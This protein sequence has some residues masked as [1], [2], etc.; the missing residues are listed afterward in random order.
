M[1]NLVDHAERELRAAGYFDEDGMYDGMIGPAVLRIVKV[2]ADENHSGM[3]AGIARA[4]FAKVV[5]FEPIGPLT[6]ED[7]EWAET[8]C[9]G[10]WQNRRCS[11]VFKEA[12]WGAYDING[13]VF[14]EPDGHTYT[15]GDSCVTVTFPYTPTTEYV[16]VPAP[17]GE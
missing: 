17:E 15:S 8:S 12:E 3:S 16:D 7:D 14:R 9:D 13:K 2:F 1:S 4:L 11:H 10:V 5:A 6:G